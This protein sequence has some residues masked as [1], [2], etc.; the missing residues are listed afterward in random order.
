[1]IEK[2]SISSA[3]TLLIGSC[4]FFLHLRKLD[5]K[6]M[7]STSISI[8]NFN[9]RCFISLER[10]C[11]LSIFHGVIVVFATKIK[12]NGVNCTFWWHPCFF[13]LLKIEFWMDLNLIFCISV[14]LSY[15]RINICKQ[16]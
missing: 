9:I 14:P 11:V 4:E 8:C 13:N 1:M 6:C 2:H 3:K 12:V 16:Y 15:N 10:M 5:M 7:P